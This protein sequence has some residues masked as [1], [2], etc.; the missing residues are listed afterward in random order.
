[1]CI[2]DRVQHTLTA[3]GRI[4]QPE[5][6]AQWVRAQVDRYDEGLLTNSQQFMNSAALKYTKI[7]S[8]SSGVFGGRATTLQ[9]DIVA[10]VTTAANK[11]KKSVSSGA[12]DSPETKK[13]TGQQPPFVKHFKSSTGSNATPYKVGDT[14][15]WNKLTWHFCDCPNHRDLSLIHI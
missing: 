1:M 15:E 14:K 7:C 10:M 2:R 11:R 5:L 12:S 13:A 9:E 6:W 4:K 8:K 3:N